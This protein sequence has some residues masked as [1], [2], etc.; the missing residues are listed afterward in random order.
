M[1]DERVVLVRIECYFKYLP[2]FL[3]SFA[4]GGKD[5]GGAHVVGG[6]K[7]PWAVHGFMGAFEA[8]TISSHRLCWW[9][10]T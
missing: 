1:L 4:F 5:G 9:Y 3:V 8:L 7:P 2:C 10:L 6:Q